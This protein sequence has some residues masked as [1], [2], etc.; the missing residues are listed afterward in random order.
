[1]PVDSTHYAKVES[2]NAV[3]RLTLDR[4]PVNVLDIA[5]LQELEIALGELAQAGD[6]RV[7]LLRA[8]GKLFSAGVDVADHTPDKVGQMIPLFDRVCR[9]L[10]DFPCPTIA[11]VH[12]HALGGGCE[13]VLCCDLVVMAEGARIGQP[14]IQLAAI[15]PIAALRLPYLV[16]YRAA[17]ELMFTG[18]ALPAEEARQIGL[19]NAVVPAAEVNEWAEQKA[20][21]IAAMSGAVL[22]LLKRALRQG[23]GH[24]AAGLPELERIYLEEVMATAD[25][26]EGLAAFMAKRP[27]VWSHQ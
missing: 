4:P 1:M 19:V 3:A 8:A 26:H 15:A 7:L 11:A 23:Y 21:A 17:A 18:R 22:P 20:G 6:V 10:A 27:A 14:E 16:G 25:A 12:G 5:F 2:A 24:W 9:L 13:L